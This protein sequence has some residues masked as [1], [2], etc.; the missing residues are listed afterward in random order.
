MVFGKRNQGEIKVIDSMTW[1]KKYIDFLN[2]CIHEPSHFTG[3]IPAYSCHMITWAETFQNTTPVQSTL[4]VVINERTFL[5]FCTFWHFYTPEKKR[6][7]LC[8]LLLLMLSNRG[9]SWFWNLSWTVRERNG[10][11]LFWLKAANIFN[12]LYLSPV[13]FNLFRADQVYGG[14]CVQKERWLSLCT[15]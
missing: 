8:C 3:V 4:C 5:V 7:L 14:S 10:L 2:Y 1:K 12:E 9:R 11:F 13:R 15:C 6:N